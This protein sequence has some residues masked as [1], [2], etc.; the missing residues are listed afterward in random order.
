MLVV[1]AAMDENCR[2]IAMLRSK[3]LWILHTKT[4]VFVLNVLI[5]HYMEE[6]WI[7]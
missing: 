4:F 6:R 5:L 1:V 7:P 3:L 2:N